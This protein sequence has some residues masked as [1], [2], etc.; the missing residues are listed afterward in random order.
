MEIDAG[1]PG[2]ALSVAAVDVAPDGT[3]F[4]ANANFAALTLQQYGVAAPIHSVTA[5]LYGASL[6]AASASLVAWVPHYSN[7]TSS[8]HVWRKVGA[9]WGLIGS[10][11]FAPAPL[12]EDY[13]AR[14]SMDGGTTWWS[15]PADGG[16]SRAPTVTFSEQTSTFPNLQLGS[17]FD[18]SANNSAW[19][20]IV[21]DRTAG[22]N[23]GTGV[24]LEWLV[25]GGSRTISAPT[26]SPLG[27]GVSRQHVVV[28]PDGRFLAR[29]RPDTNEVFLW[30]NGV[31][32][33][34][35]SIP[36]SGYLNYSRLLAMS[37]DGNVVIVGY[38][39][40]VSST[41]AGTNLDFYFWNGSSYV[42]GDVMSLGFMR[43]E[44]LALSGDGRVLAISGGSFA[45]DELHIYRRS[46]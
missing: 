30:R 38:P 6:H 9:S 45:P 42:L 16:L 29:L 7:D 37:D 32:V 34:P 23:C 44:H 40:V 46:S 17:L 11:G 3:V 36:L 1:P 19:V 5:N 4:F 2:V 31:L 24:V 8:I 13:R 28:S 15:R 18:V 10:R 20:P 12:G 25:D 33:A 43:P 14:V 27:G 21:C 22:T 39:R 41:P 26:P 35:L